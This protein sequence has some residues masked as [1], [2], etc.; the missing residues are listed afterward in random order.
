MTKLCPPKSKSPLLLYVSSSNSAVSA[1]LVQEKEEEG[2]L[3]Q[4]PVYFAS[5]ALFGSKIFYS[6][7]EKI[8]YAVIMAARKL[9]HY[10]EGHRIRVITNQP[11]NDLLANRET[12][13]RSS[14]G[15]LNSQNT[16]WTSRKE[17]R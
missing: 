15:V 2:K 4:I 14:S 1:V 5:E 6:E 9:R 17:T 3:K 11:L 13:T 8:T 7:L 12:S 10:F 16:L